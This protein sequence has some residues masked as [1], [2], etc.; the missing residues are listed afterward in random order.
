MF[1]TFTHVMSRD[2][3]SEPGLPTI[4]SVFNLHSLNRH[5]PH[6]CISAF[7]FLWNGAFALCSSKVCACKQN[8]K[9]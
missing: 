7:S 4:V 9:S 8:G 3:H 1:S 5:H 2:T 6:D